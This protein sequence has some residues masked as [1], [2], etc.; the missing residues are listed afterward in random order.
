MRHSIIIPVFN[1]EKHIGVCLQALQSQRDVDP[2]SYEIL[3]VDNNS[4][5]ASAHIA[6]RFPGV[7]VFAEARQ[8]AYAARNCGV[9][10]ARASEALVFVD[11][12]CQPEERWLRNLTAPLS[13]PGVEMVMGHSL[14]AG[15]SRAARLLE[16]YEMEKIRFIL[17]SGRGELVYAYTNNL[18][19]STDLFRRAGPFVE[20]L[21]GGD[22]L[23]ARAAVRL[24][25]SLSFI[26][27]AGD[28]RVKHHELRSV[29]DYVSKMYVYG[30]SLQANRT[31]DPLRRPLTIGQRLR[32]AVRVL[33]SGRS[34]LSDFP[35]LLGSL[36][37]GMFAYQTGRLSALAGHPA[38]SGPP[39]R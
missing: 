25:G 14:F 2:S 36:A 23:F 17:E 34:G 30:R 9:R 24:H 22:T 11:P 32:V 37:A 38:R 39:S 21:R 35:R 31:L 29:R 28:A 18:A 27:L 15:R 33:R 1:A 5:D 16:S 10:E 20:V 4:T 12:D 7:R 6:R 19:V 3:V 26:R 13:Q 8:G